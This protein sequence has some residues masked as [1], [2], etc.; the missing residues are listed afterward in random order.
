MVVIAGIERDAVERTGGCDAA[1]HVERAIAVEGSYL[2]GDDIVDCRKAPPEIRAEDDAADRRLQIEANQRN[3]ARHC[4]AMPDDLVFGGRFHRCEAEQP[5]MI[6]DAARRFCFGNRLLCRTDQAG[7]HRQRPSGPGGGGLGGELEHL[8]VHAGLADR[9]LRS[10]NTDRK[11]TGAGVDIIA[12]QRALVPDIELAAGIQR[13][14]MRGE[15]GA[16]RDQLAYLG[17]DL[18]MMHEARS[19]PNSGPATAN[20][21]SA[22]CVPARPNRMR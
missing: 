8:A 5:G 3:L 21:S 6:A 9:E 4:L 12:A 14:R 22:P 10:V 15:Y 11:A 1:Q 18:A 2:D 19:Y 13:Q 20:G 7:N 16:V 17:L